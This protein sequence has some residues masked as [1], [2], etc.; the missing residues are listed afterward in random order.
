MYTTYPVPAQSAWRLTRGGIPFILRCT[1]LLSSSEAAFLHAGVNGVG[2]TDS[3][4][5][6]GLKIAKDYRALHRKANSYLLDANI[7]MLGYIYLSGIVALTVPGS[8]VVATRTSVGVYRARI[9]E[10]DYTR[11]TS[12]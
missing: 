12:T 11:K 10:Y 5:V 1:L 3:G 8:I 7:H 2:L 6:Q 9:H 4:L